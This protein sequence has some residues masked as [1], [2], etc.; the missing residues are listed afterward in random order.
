M[1]ALAIDRNR[2]D[3]TILSSLLWAYGFSVDKA[4]DSREA[5]ALAGSN[6]YDLVVVDMDMDMSDFRAFYGNLLV[7][8]PQLAGKVILMAEKIKRESEDFLS[9]TSCPFVRKPFLTLELLK[10]VDGVVE[11]TA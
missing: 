4:A 11:N 7:T 6:R 5:V 8:F 2:E 1:R 10:T 3:L 9:E